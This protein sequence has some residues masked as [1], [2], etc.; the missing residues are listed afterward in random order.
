MVDI[1]HRKTICLNMIVK[2]ESHIIASTLKNILEH[3]KIDYWVISDTGSTDDTVDIIQH[4]FKERGISGEIF[5]DKWKDF[6]HNRT[7]A[8]EHAYNKSDYLF[9]FDADDLIHG[10]MQL[11]STLDKD[12]YDLPFGNPVSYHRSILISNRM[13]WKYVG[14]LHELLRNV[15]PIKSRAYLLG[16]YNIESRRLGDRS[17]NP[18]KYVDDALVLEKGFEEENTDLWLKYRYAYYC[19]Q[20]YNDAGKWEKAIEWYE[21]TLT[22]DYSPQYKYCACV[23]AGDCYNVLKQYSNA[24]DSWS[25]AYSYDK[26]RLEGIVKIMAYFYN[27]GQHFMVL[28]LYNKF[29]HVKI[30]NAK[31]KI[32]LDYSKYHDFHYFASISGCYCD[33]HKSAYEACKYMLLNNTWSS[34]NTIYN[35]KF[36]MNHFKED[37]DNKSLLDY[38]VAYIM[39]PRIV[40]KERKNAWNIV[41]SI[42]KEQLPDKYE[43]LENIITTPQKKNI[44]KNSKYASSKNILIYTGYMNF[45]WND[46]TLN[47]KAIGGAEKAVIYLTRN[48]PKNYTIYIAGDQKE[49]EIGNIKYINHSNLQKLLDNTI[50][51]SIIVSRYVS[52]FKEFDNIK[53]YKMLLSAHDSTGFIN[54]KVKNI[55]IN[56]ILSEYNKYIDNVICLTKWHSSNIVERHPFLKE[57]INI[58]NNGIDISQFIYDKPKVKN[59]FVWSSCS[60]R[61]LIILLNLWGELLKSIPDATL[62]I[63][64][65]DIF[66]KNKEDEKML[67]IINKHSSITHHGKLNTKQ[68]YDLMSISEY[69][70]YTNTFPETSCITAMEMLM[71]GAICLY[72]PLAGL[73]DTIGNYGIQVKSGNEI[74]TLMNLSEENKTELIKNGKE[75]ALACSW[76]NRAEQWCNMLGL[77]KKKWIFYC[78]SNFETKMI[79]Q[80]I[81]N[82]NCVYPEYDI[83]LTNDREVILTTSPIKVT[84]VY[85]VFDNDLTSKLPSTM[86][87]FLNTEPLNIPVR[88][89]PIINILKLYPNLEYYDYSESNLK[90]LEEN[91]INIQNKIYL[92]YKCSDEELEK[93]INLNKNTKKE[94]DFGIIKTLGGVITERRLKIVNFLKENNFTVNII[95]GWDHDRD[96]ELAKC[97][98]IL[99]IHGN[100]G[101]TISYIFEHI[102]CNRLLESGFNI[103]SETSYKMNIEFINKNPNLKFIDYN[104]FFN[105]DTIIVF[106]NNKLGTLAHNNYVL[107]ILKDT[108]TRIDIPQV[109]INFL[110]E[111]KEHL[112]IDN[113][114]IYDIGSSV[115][116]WTQHASKIWNNS[117]IYLFDAM[118]EMKLFYDEYNKQNN[119]NYEYNIGVLCDEDYKRISFYQNDELSGG[120]SYYK[121]IGHRDSDTIFTENHIKHKIGM[122]LETVVKN[123]NI[124]MPDLIKI[125]VQGAELD[126]LKGSMSIINK[127]KFLIVELQHTEYNQGAPLCDQTRDFLID[128]G[129]QV[130]A[131]KFSNNGP[132]AD[133]CFINTRYNDINNH[134]TCKSKQTIKKIYDTLCLNKNP[135]DYYLNPI[136]IYEHLPTLYKYASECNSVLECG[137]RASVSSW[138]LVYGLINN[139]SDN[140][141]LIL[142]DIE[143]C[144]VSKLLEYTKSISHLNVSYEWVSDLDLDLKENVDLTFIDSWHVGGHLKK[145]LAKFSKLTNK[146]II[147][148]DTTIDE[149]TSEA[150]RAN[151]TEEQIKELSIASSMSVDDVKMGLWTAIDDF[152]KNN[153]DWGLHERFHN[154]NG[155]TILKKINNKPKIVDCFTFYNELEMLN[156]RLNILN[157]VVDYFVLV[158]ATHT[159]VGKEKPLFYQENK[160]LFEKFN[161]KIIHIIVDDFTHKFPNINIEKEEQWIN[162]RY[163]RDCIS[164]GI[165]KLHLQHNDVITITDLDEIPN[166]KLLKKIKNNEIKV[167]INIIEMDL[168]YNNLNSKMDHQ[169]Q[170]SKILTFQKYNELKIG[171]DKLRFYSCPIIKNAGWHLSYF[172]NEKFIKNKIENFGH[173]EYNKVEF[174]DE[175][176]IR[177]RIKNGNDLFDRPVSIINIP[178][179]DNNNLPPDYDIYLTN[180]YTNK[181][182]NKNIGFFIRHFSE[183]G[184]EVAIY[185]YAHY[186]ENILGN[187]SYI[188]HFSDNVQKKYGFPDIKVSFPKF[189]SRFEM[190]EINDIT[191]MNLVIE[192]YKLDF[193]YTLTHGGQDI[194]QFNNNSIW[195]K[196]KTIKH[197]VF[198]TLCP[199]GDYNLSISNHLNNKNNTSYTVLPHMVDLPNTDTHLRNELNIPEEAIVLGRYGGFHQFDLAITHNAIKQFL[200]SNKSNNVYFLFMNTFEFYSHPNIIYL[201]KNIDLLYK[202]NFINTCDAMIHARSDGETFGLCIAEFSI[203]NKPIITCPCGDLEHILLL[204]DKAITYNNTEELLDIFSNIKELF[205]QHS[206][207][208]CYREYTPEKV[209]DIFDN[210]LSN[211]KLETNIV[212][213]NNVKFKFFK[214]DDLAKSSIALNIPWEPHITSFVEYYNKYFPIQ[215]IIDIG[216]NFGYHSLLFSK[217]VKN[218][219]FSFE[220]QEQNYNLLSFNINFNNIKNICSYKMACGEENDTI[221]M[222]IVENYNNSINM[223]DFT[224]NIINKHNFTYVKSVKLDYI[225]FPPIDIIKIDVQGWEKKVLKGSYNLLQHHKPILII[226]FEEYQ[227]NKLNECCKNLIEYIRENNYYIFYL[228]YKY[229]SD[230]ICVHNDKLN[231]FKKCF[232]SVIST[233]TQDNNINHNILYN[234]NEKIKF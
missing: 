135:F 5:H 20:S 41:N 50:F 195:D 30:G 173:Q 216:A 172:G 176:K 8:L 72:Y 181:K 185:D 17:K 206:D 97:K 73:V 157:D 24:I 148:H 54:F 170:H 28:A 12:A 130:Y 228:D 82:L 213:I 113:M 69:W 36:Y 23:R 145:E 143:P 34:S 16:N 115:L 114:I 9:V 121:E 165:N 4:F 188:I 151:L 48:L 162:E 227:L 70:L 138:A 136:D 205:S 45:L 99:N 80:Y 52:F 159:H 55:T 32:F 177:E 183:R 192:K 93:L 43:I 193:F 62:D 116:H 19:G 103:L 133:W 86:F 100:L 110:K 74:E 212:T 58:I 119:T 163:Q 90:I 161:H 234:I 112:N 230:H 232:N 217:Y 174:T 142:N 64:S 31:D 83:Y 168:Y 149:F 18:N 184:T 81:D 71:S 197:C 137:V 218:K 117:K 219:V 167:D 207:W 158:E 38:F 226:E 180:F 78:S 87:G 26:E 53:C 194:Y 7:K 102:R 223:G 124:P 222:P 179:E 147:M 3:I 85:E 107:N 141:K 166:P 155:L 108:H 182:T 156:Y 109:H 111:L 154:N 94:Y 186:N 118:T 120:N 201:D 127:A 153:N 187:K 27:K 35:L 65:Y 208:N 123:K 131:E 66:P 89:E 96:T 79:R 59:K 198:D 126:I 134:I 209:M 77:N 164:R 92:P 11:P 144:D 75:Y 140:K 204:G 1:V 171:C 14:V 63:C 106:Y 56:N 2:N 39:N 104:E 125:D 67:E 47:K 231:E 15:D 21:R 128:H 233:H 98:I 160:H 44:D 61:G 190:I 57:K 105:I 196:C 202:T 40:F 101:T 13:K 229:P 215:N 220:P 203:K 211:Y 88:L 76:G 191:D 33:E 139:N 199:E 200:D 221:K 95:D 25:K 169:W 146:Y 46:S 152:L 60:Y 129:W 178:I 29:K 84:F 175:K 37:D 224:P 214:D 51:H 6:G 22:L 150:I 122:K 210:I 91:E 10:D 42:I 68:L 189:N 132:D 225:D 49:E